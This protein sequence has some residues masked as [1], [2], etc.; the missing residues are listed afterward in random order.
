MTKNYWYIFKMAQLFSLK[1][2]TLL[3]LILL[4][5]IF[6]FNSVYAQQAGKDLIEAKFD[7]WRQ[8][9]LQEKIYLHTDKANY[10]TGEICWF[11]IYNVNAYNH[12]PI[13]F[14][15][16]AYVEVLDRNNRA[17]LQ[18][19]IGLGKG[20][21]NGSFYLPATLTTGNYKIRAYTNWMKNNGVDYFFEKKLVIINV[22]KN[23][24]ASATVEKSL[25]DIGFFP[26]GGNLVNG[27]ESK[28]GFKV[29]NQWGKGVEF[30][31]LLL[32]EKG[33]TITRFHPFKFGMGSFIFTPITGAQYRTVVKLPGGEEQVKTLP[34]PY[35]SGYSMRLQP[36]VN[37]KLIIKVNTNEP[38]NGYSVFLF[39]HTRN[40]VKVFSTAV[41]QNGQA[42]FV[43]DSR[44]LEDGISQFTIFNSGRQPVC[45][46]LYFKQPQ[47]ALR[48]TTIADQAQYGLRK[49]IN[50]EINSAKQQDEAVAANMSMAV[51]RVDDFTQPDIAGIDNYLLLQSDIV[52]Q[53]ESPAYYFTINDDT[54]ATAADNLM[55]TQGWRRFRWNDV[56]Q[57]KKSA[58]QFLPEMYGHVISGKLIPLLPGLPVKDI[59]VYLT[60]PG[61][62]T[63]F[64][65]AAADETGKIKFDM[66]DLYS[67]GDIIVQTNNEKDSGYRI[68]IDTP[69]V[70]SFSQKPSVNY[71]VATPNETLLKNYIASQV[72][73]TFLYKQLNHATQNLA[74]TN[75]FYSRPVATY[76]L[77]NYV[78]FTTLEEVFREYV[79]EVGVRKRGGKFYLP[80]YD[81]WS[82]AFFVNDPLLLLDGLPV[83]NVDKAMSYDPLK[84]RKLEVVNKKYFLRDNSF[85][86][87]INLI[88]YKGDLE[89]FDID[90]RATIVNYE[91]LQVQRDFY[92][93]VYATEQQLQSRMPDFRNLLYWSP[94]INTANNGKTK[95]SFYTSD[96]PGRYVVVAEGISKDGSAGESI[97]YFEVKK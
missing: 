65:T 62:R 70:N 3:G 54:V 69:F 12:Q 91:G 75:A 18:A 21:G 43:T 46:R 33:D 97:M 58:V 44:Q 19:K 57:D 79:V 89:G 4:M 32:N 37:G 77:D 29:N 40:V 41:I 52:G 34:A 71:A 47:H 45:E 74:D 42:E 15:K 93:P 17:V 5:N 88:T 67:D 8:N 23:T 48:I 14:G 27:I 95:A 59:P 92:A 83:F 84:I 11:K 1:A 2:A 25:Y 26:E 53:V 49:K 82:K 96:I 61:I 38:A 85:D 51:Y 6:L 7:A 9:N 16:V 60:V 68:E 10:V 90:P 36:G 76:L 80:M 31:G 20:V 55:L 72:Q 78:R 56:M 39:V 87:I 35:N 24:S 30:E 22:Q 66:K 94:E 13:D 63:Q 64:Q 73:N 28:V 86:G 50:I 81:S